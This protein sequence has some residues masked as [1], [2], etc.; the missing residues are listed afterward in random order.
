MRNLLLLIKIDSEKKRFLYF[1][2][3]NFIITTLVLQ[4]LLLF[5]ET[6]FA[7]FISQTTNLIIGFSLYRKKVFQIKKYTLKTIIKYI[8]LSLS[9][10]IINWCS[11]NYLTN[12]FIVNKNIA[13][14]FVIPFL[15][16][17]SFFG[18]K[19]LV[20]KSKS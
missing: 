6:Y 7:T 13:A 16:M 19:K 11:I 3:I 4:F 1:G 12:L 5:S 17:I 8:L 10:W 14:F 15:V 9:L 18:Q 2:T 20:F